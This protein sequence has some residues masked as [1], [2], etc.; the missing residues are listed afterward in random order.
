MTDNDAID[1][2][3]AAREKTP[4][5]PFAAGLLAIAALMVGAFVLGLGVAVGERLHAGTISTKGVAI[6]AIVLVLAG[7][8]LSWL[9][10]KLKPALVLPRS[11]NMRR[12]KM[13]MIAS[14][15]IGVLL[16]MGASLADGGA[17]SLGKD[18]LSSAPVSPLYASVVIIIL[19]LA[20]APTLIWYRSVD[21][22]ER[23]AYDFGSN[24]ALHTYFI[25][26][27]VWWMAWRGGLLPAPDGIVIYFL[28]AI[29]WMAAWLWRRAH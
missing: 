20:F 24:F 12:A 14:V 21:E 3:A 1:T 6:I 8:V 10:R 26:A 19:L 23:L 27:P 16:G 15:S 18:F 5:G 9:L 4:P 25:G 17:A 13:A 2:V 28:T 22:H 29:V 7:V 11:P